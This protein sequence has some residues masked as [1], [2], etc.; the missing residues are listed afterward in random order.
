MLAAP[1]TQEEQCGWNSGE[2]FGGGQSCLG[3]SDSQPMEMEIGMATPRADGV[4][5]DFG[6]RIDRPCQ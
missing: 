5:I 3:S 6:G 2:W 1:G 4:E